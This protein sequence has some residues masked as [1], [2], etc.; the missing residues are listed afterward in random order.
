MGIVAGGLGVLLV[1]SPLSLCFVL[2]VA[3]PIPVQQD[4][5]ITL[6]DRNESY[7]PGRPLLLQSSVQPSYLL[8]QWQCL[9]QPGQQECRLWYVLEHE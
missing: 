2:M 8:T 3:N 7:L 9:L 4:S 1:T 5:V 6:W